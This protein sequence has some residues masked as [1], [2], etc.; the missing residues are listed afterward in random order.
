MLEKCA[1]VA[2]RGRLSIP[3]WEDDVESFLPG[4]LCQEL[5]SHPLL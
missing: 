2:K 3:F 1:D 4:L 5:S